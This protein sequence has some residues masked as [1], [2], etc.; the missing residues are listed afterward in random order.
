MQADAFRFFYLKELAT[1]EDDLSDF[2]KA[3]PEIAANLELGM[4]GISD[5]NI[6]H[7]VEAVAFI[8]ARLRMQLNKI[9]GN[10][11]Y[12]IL[13]SVAPELTEP[14]PCM[15]V[16]RLTP[17]DTRL[18]VP[19]DFN[20]QTN[21][22]R[23]HAKHAGLP[24]AIPFVCCTTDIKLWFLDVQ[25]SWRNT[26]PDRISVSD[27]WLLNNR[28]VVTQD[29][30]IHL[31][32]LTK[33]IS[34]GG[35][36]ELTFFISGPITRALAA[37]DALVIGCVSIRMEATDGSWGV[38]IPKTALQVLGFQSKHRLLPCTDRAETESALM[39][40]YVRFP[41][42]FCFFKLSGLRV[43]KAV[44]EFCLVFKVKE[45]WVPAI[46]S[47]KDFFILNCLPAVNIS[48]RNKVTI[49]INS[50]LEKI[51]IPGPGHPYKENEW[52]VYRVDQV[53]L[54]DNTTSRVLPR[55][56]HGAGYVGEDLYFWKFMRQEHLTGQNSY[57][58]LSLE[59][60]AAAPGGGHEVLSGSMRLAIDV[61]DV[62]CHIPEQ[63]EMGAQLQVG[64]TSIPC[65]AQMEI[66]PTAYLPPL[67]SSTENLGKILNLLRWRAVD[68]SDVIKFIGEYMQF[69]Y[70]GLGPVVRYE[71]LALLGLHRE[72]I[73]FPMTNA[74][75]GKGV[76]SI[77]YRYYIRFSSGQEGVFSRYIFSGLIK[78]ILAH[79]HDASFPIECQLVDDSDSS[80][81]CL[82]D[83]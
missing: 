11:I 34:V 35:P 24:D 3:Y 80:S 49:P 15:S 62:F 12:E 59:Q 46:D 78:T 23:V 81:R 25:T 13:Q 83:V 6:K 17:S 31:S 70:P 37:I 32:H 66:S 18:T 21:T 65:R 57:G 56:R 75:K 42:R 36:E 68:S 74:V 61:H 47:V 16:I 10:L 60:T 69:R 73:A 51:R 77:G 38:D 27:E 14:V 82:I 63:I 55:F 33:K 28:S 19:L 20:F 52:A 26:N 43:P 71:L 39:A 9:P 67:L 30:V 4:G 45:A 64:D 22:L 1:F 29:F 2:A 50:V 54:F 48:K 58:M 76:F 53:V 5:P 79:F 72:I 44:S 41:R 7:L 40:E 8:A